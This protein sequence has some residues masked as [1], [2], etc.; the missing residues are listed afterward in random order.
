MVTRP[1]DLSG[2]YAPTPAHDSP[3]PRTPDEAEQLRSRAGLVREHARSV[4]A[5]S[6]PIRFADIARLDAGDP[7][8]V[9]AESTREEIRAAVGEYALLL[10]DLGTPPEKAVVAVKSMVGEAACA[11]DSRPDLIMPA[12]VRWAI[13]AYY[14]R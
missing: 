4:V 14:S 13:E 7:L 2:A 3:R 11:S 9:I 5:R 1:S 6:A 10:R 8:L 12:I